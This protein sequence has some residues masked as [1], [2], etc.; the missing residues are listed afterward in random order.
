MIWLFRR[1]AQKPSGVP[2]EMLSD[3][4]RDD[5][6]VADLEALFRSDPATFGRYTDVEPGGGAAATNL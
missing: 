3:H 5:H 1:Y 2:L 6:R 4:P